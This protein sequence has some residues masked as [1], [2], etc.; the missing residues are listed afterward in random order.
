M[1]HEFLLTNE[2][3]RFLPLWQFLPFGNRPFLDPTLFIFTA[4]AMP[5]RIATLTLPALD[6]RFRRQTGSDY[7]WDICTWLFGY[8]AI[9][10]TGFWFQIGE[11]WCA[12]LKWSYGGRSLVAIPPGVPPGI[13]AY[14]II[15]TF[16][17]WVLAF[18]PISF[19]RT[20]DAKQNDTL[21]DVEG[22]EAGQNTT[23]VL[24]SSTTTE[25]VRK[26]PRSGNKLVLGWRLLDLARVVPVVLISGWQVIP[27]TLVNTFIRFYLVDQIRRILGRRQPTR[28][29]RVLYLCLWLMIMDTLND[30]DVQLIDR[31]QRSRSME[32]FLWTTYFHRKRM[33]RGYRENSSSLVDKVIRG[34]KRDEL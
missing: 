13:D 10:L 6:A 26:S 19:S 2:D 7:L 3:H 24:G 5:L 22:K 34:K 27:I 12:L 14:E 30:M 29:R 11:V 15:L 1:L 23:D 21:L 16:I 28:L 8:Y 25:N 9:C 17:G 4:V 18:T 20:E 32:D 33:E 31:L